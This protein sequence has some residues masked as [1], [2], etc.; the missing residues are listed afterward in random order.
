MS[1]TY[2]YITLTTRSMQF[3]SRVLHEFTTTQPLSWASR[4]LYIACHTVNHPRRCQNSLSYHFC[5]RRCVEI[6][7]VVERQLHKSHHLVN[8]SSTTVFSTTSKAFCIILRIL[9][10]TGQ[11]VVDKSEESCIWKGAN[12]LSDVEVSTP[13]FFELLLIFIVRTELLTRTD[14]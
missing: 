11:T 14:L 8:A 6:L 2:F 3:S 13:Q 4:T 12:A 9:S 1:A 5:S 7:S 10:N